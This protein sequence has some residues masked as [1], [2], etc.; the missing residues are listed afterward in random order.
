MMPYQWTF[1]GPISKAMGLKPGYAIMRCE[2]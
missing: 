2:V 1:T